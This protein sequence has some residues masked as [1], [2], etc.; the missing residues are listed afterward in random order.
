MVYYSLKLDELI[1]DYCYVDSETGVN[2]LNGLPFKS[3]INTL[4]WLNSSYFIVE[5]HIKQFI[6]KE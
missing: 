3:V 6:K 2:C 5:S 1:N 4:E